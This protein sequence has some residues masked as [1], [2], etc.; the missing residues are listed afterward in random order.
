[1]PVVGLLTIS[2]DG[3]VMAALRRGLER[4]GFVEGR[5]VAIVVR[6]ADGEFE[7][8]PQLAA[9]LVE[10][11]VSVILTW[12]SS[13]PAQAAKAA[14]NKIPIVFSYGGDPVADGLVPNFN[15]PGGNVTGVTVSGSALLAKRLELARSIVPG[16]TDVA[17]LI[18]S[19]TGS[20]AQ[21]QT[22]AA[23]AAAPQLGLTVHIVDATGEEEIDRAFAT[24]K[25]PKIGALI[26]S[27]DPLF[28]FSRRHQIVAL[29]ARY[30]LPTIFGLRTGPDAGG[31]ISYG[32]MAED[33]WEQ[34]GG[35]VARI[36]KGEKAADLPI[37]Q[38]TRFETVVNLKT[39]KALGLEIPPSVLAA[40]SEVIE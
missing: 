22:A 1:L 33:A 38:G 20:L 10:R 2:L 7:R 31:L 35:Y 27:T 15:R 17:L 24:L 11:Q 12:G 4:G 36:L 30:R 26:L 34:A 19:K 9:E 37:I 28:A 18:N 29:A 40:A 23:Q 16:L 32:T 14:T 13:V 3:G 8:F 25:R 6:S 21:G 5:N 39:A